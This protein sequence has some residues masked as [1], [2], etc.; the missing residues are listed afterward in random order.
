M[1]EIYQYSLDGIF[2]KEW[3]NCYDAA[4]FYN[5]TEMAIRNNVKN[6]TKS[7]KG[8]IWKTIERGLQS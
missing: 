3:N 4:K 7:S 2:I 8:F 6:R 5:C 1:I